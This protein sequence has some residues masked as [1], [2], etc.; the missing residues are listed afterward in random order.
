MTPTE[1]PT[2]GQRDKAIGV[3]LYQAERSLGLHYGGDLPPLSYRAQRILDAA[4][5]RSLDPRLY[6]VAW[7]VRRMCQTRH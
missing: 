5:E 7:F 2:D 6:Q 1:E 4:M 3:A